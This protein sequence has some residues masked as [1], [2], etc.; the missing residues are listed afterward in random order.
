MPSNKPALSLSKKSALAFVAHRTAAHEMDQLDP[1]KTR[2]SSVNFNLPEAEQKRMNELAEEHEKTNNAESLLKEALRDAGKE[3]QTLCERSSVLQVQGLMNNVAALIRSE[4]R[5]ILAQVIDGFSY[6]TV[7]LEK[8]AQIR[9]FSL[10][11][12]SSILWK[13]WCTWQDHVRVQI[14]LQE[15]Q[16]Q[17]ADCQRI[18]TKIK[19]F[20]AY[21]AFNEWRQMLSRSEKEASEKTV[22]LNEAR[23][24][25]AAEIEEMKEVHKE[26]VDKVLNQW[27]GYL[28]K[29]GHVMEEVV[30][31]WKAAEAKYD[32][33]R[34]QSLTR[35]IMRWRKKGLSNAWY[36]WL[37][38]W[39]GLQRTRMEV[40]RF[41]SKS[42]NRS[43]RRIFNSWRDLAK[44]CSQE[45]KQELSVEQWA[46]RRMTGLRLKNILAEWREQARRD[47]LRIG[48]ALEGWAQHAWDRRRQRQ[49]AALLSAR[50]GL[51]QQKGAWAVWFA[52]VD[53]TIVRHQ[54]IFDQ[55]RRRV[56]RITIRRWA[57]VRPVALFLAEV[58]YKIGRNW[59]RTE[60]VLLIRAWQDVVLREV[61]EDSHLKR[62]ARLSDHALSVGQKES[63]LEE[64]RVQQQEEAWRLEAAA[65]QQE[66]TR[67]NQA[68]EAEIQRAEATWLEEEKVRQLELG[69][70]NRAEAERLGK[71]AK[72]MDTAQKKLSF[73]Q[74]ESMHK[75][76]ETKGNMQMEKGHVEEFMRRLELIVKREWEEGVIWTAGREQLPERFQALEHSVQTTMEAMA[77]RELALG[78]QEDTLQEREASVA[79]QQAAVSRLEQELQAQ[80]KVSDLEREETRRMAVAAAALEEE[81]QLQGKH[82]ERQQWK[83]NVKV[84]AERLRLE[85]ER[86]Q[87]QQDALAELE[88]QTRSVVLTADQEVQTEE[89]ERQLDWER[90]L[91]RSRHRVREIE[92]PLEQ[93]EMHATEDAEELQAEEQQI[94]HLRQLLRDASKN[95]AKQRK[96]KREGWI[97]M[98][99][100]TA[101]NVRRL[102]EGREQLIK[103]REDAYQAD[104]AQWR[105]TK[106]ISEAIRRC[107]IS[108]DGAEPTEEYLQLLAEKYA[109]RWK[110][111]VVGIQRIKQQTAWAA[112]LNKQR[113]LQRT[114]HR[115]SRNSKQAEPKPKT[116]QVEEEVAA[117]PIPPPP[118]W[119]EKQLEGVERLV[120]GRNREAQLS[121]SLLQWLRARRGKVLP[122]KLTEM[123]S[124]LF[125]KRAS[126][127]MRECLEEWRAVAGLQRLRRRTAAH[128]GKLLTRMMQRNV[129]LSIMQLWQSMMRERRAGQLSNMQIRL[130]RMSSER[131]LL[132]AQSHVLFP[133][134]KH[135]KAGLDYYNKNS[136]SAPDALKCEEMA[137]K[138]G[139]TAEM[140]QLL[141]KHTAQ[142][143]AELTEDDSMANY[144][145]PLLKE[146]IEGAVDLL[147]QELQRMQW[148]CMRLQ[149]ECK[150]LQGQ[151]D[152]LESSKMSD[153]KRLIRLFRRKLSVV[154]AEGEGRMYSR[155]QQLA[156][157]MNTHSVHTWL[158]ELRKYADK[159]TLMASSYFQASGDCSES[160]DDDD[161]REAA[162]APASNPDDVT[163]TDTGSS[164]G[165]STLS[166]PPAQFRSLLSRGPPQVEQMTYLDKADG[167]M[168]GSLRRWSGLRCIW[169]RGADDAASCFLLQ[170]LV[171]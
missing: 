144:S 92:A 29:E 162:L 74:L 60:A 129:K 89:E 138:A 19:A 22:Q 2:R 143:L 61:A 164:N 93:A 136:P 116:P 140:L 123:C 63:E 8:A 80:V 3:L 12:T 131:P 141:E 167:G 50:H 76:Y 171:Q 155:V 145:D 15:H 160:D 137:R 32:K 44:D 151:L 152:R 24:Q 98:H 121:S 23:A 157:A 68:R 170:G 54:A 154:L 132:V 119:T 48:T 86:A 91:L 142:T 17:S 150:A 20:C 37:D 169:P 85:E 51:G 40:E 117:P 166:L 5:E 168:W 39:E 45:K 30:A 14:E 70:Q 11:W 102:E 13:A 103:L 38:N 83:D 25:H 158:D 42:A 6:G 27:K 148:G 58:E 124:R 77:S 115:L 122:I 134:I 112:E 149:T 110:W 139:T 130:Q 113:T 26:E 87:L 10:R 108:M 47:R 36:L 133:L 88:A 18:L 101:G 35:V 59:K 4:L 55:M 66:E 53:A 120:E 159:D 163:T 31:S 41:S 90:G 127:S 147:A 114:F 52:E 67:E 81:L 46:D 107:R 135:A 49:I 56:M 7:Q 99:T 75:A 33:L 96:K 72:E 62:E 9:K 82:Q 165:N 95:R 125:A 64:V 109:R 94:Q 100:G 153:R 106:Q 73:E 146:A 65:A 34:T 79:E 126:K 71:L 161:A 78:A 105:H 16:F 118:R 97:L 104:E 128:G 156:F 21:K 111:I 57:G 69:E 43:Y 28:E 84:E 1:T